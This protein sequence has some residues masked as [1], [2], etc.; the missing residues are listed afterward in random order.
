MESLS[1]NTIAMLVVSII[2][3]ALALTI[4]FLENTILPAASPHFS[5]YNACVAPVITGFSGSS[6]GV[7]LIC[8]TRFINHLIFGS[9]SLDLASLTLPYLG[10]PTI[11]AAMY[12]GRKGKWT[13]LLPIFSFALFNIHPVGQQA[14][15]YSLYWIIPV[16]CYFSGSTFARCLGA[17]F[18]AHAVGSVIWLYCFS[19]TAEQWMALIPL[20]IVERLLAASGMY[21]AYNIMRYAV[22]LASST[23]PARALRGLPPLTSTA[24]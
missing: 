12:F 7:A 24:N 3:V 19:L 18:T 16:W 20:V 11:A 17:T 9:A 23:S 6:L 14:W 13:L 4:I 22:R 15:L 8:F 5:W 10:I 1:K 21:V 2:F